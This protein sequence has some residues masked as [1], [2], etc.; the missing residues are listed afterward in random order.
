MDR[1]LCQYGIDKYIGRVTGTIRG[2][3]V[4]EAL[5]DFCRILDDGF[6]DE[7]YLR[8]DPPNLTTLPA[9]RRQAA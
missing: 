3:G 5:K 8:H 6:A 9:V 1:F 7:K 4:F 2:K